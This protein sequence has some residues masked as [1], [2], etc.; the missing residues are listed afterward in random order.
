MNRRRFII[1]FSCLL[2]IV[3]VYSVISA[4]LNSFQYLVVSSNA[5]FNLKVYP[6]EHDADTIKKSQTSPVKSLDKP[7]KYRL[8]KGLYFY[9]YKSPNKDFKPVDGNFD[10]QAKKYF[11][12]IKDFAYTD[13]KLSDLL[14]TEQSDINKAIMNKYS[15][16]MNSYEI[17][18]SKLY[19]KGD[20]YGATLYSKDRE[21]LDDLKIIL[22][23]ENN[24]WVVATNPPDIVLS[25]P[26]YTNIPFDILSQVNNN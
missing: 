6:A 15:Q 21:N 26:V 7:G 14:V 22:K 23:K 2:F 8:K 13:Q 20:W 19:H 16:Q 9:T 3:I 25:S 11:I 1:I 5:Q 17:K 10:L 4:Y 24:A 18:N 12:N